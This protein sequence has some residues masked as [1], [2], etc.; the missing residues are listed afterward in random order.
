MHYISGILITISLISSFYFGIKAQSTPENIVVY[1][2]AGISL[3]GIKVWGIYLMISA[4][5]LVFP[6]TFI[7][8]NVMMI[9][10]SLFTL[11]CFLIIKDAKG[12]GMEFIYMMVPILL[13][14]IGYP[15][16]FLSSK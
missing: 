12:A 4:I 3:I 14:I 7:Y 13:L 15:V 1:N 5:L 2:S 11:S 10:N 16:N 9:L 6:R 8:G